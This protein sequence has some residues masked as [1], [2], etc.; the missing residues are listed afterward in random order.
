MLPAY[1][2]ITDVQIRDDPTAAAASPSRR[3]SYAFDAVAST[4]LA[5]EKVQHTPA[6]VPEYKYTYVRV[7]KLQTLAMHSIAAQHRL[8]NCVQLSLV[9]LL[10][11][12]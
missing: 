7:S 9:W 8:Q 12:T 2:V 3:P 5:G 4:V 11:P 6:D 1:L 10:L